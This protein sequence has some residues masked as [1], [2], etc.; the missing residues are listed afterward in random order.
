MPP[1]ITLP[2]DRRS[3]RMAST[4][5]PYLGS[6]TPYARERVP[7]IRCVPLPLI[8]GLSRRIGAVIVPEKQKSQCGIGLHSLPS[9]V[10]IRRPFCAY[11]PGPARFMT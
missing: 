3:S 2:R 9:R 4:A 11:G 10:P 7:K 5:L 1:K 6:E 8:A